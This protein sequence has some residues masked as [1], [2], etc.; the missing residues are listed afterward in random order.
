MAVELKFGVMFEK[1]ESFRTKSASED[2]AKTYAEDQLR[3][4]N[5]KF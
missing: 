4:K 3:K 1:C 2:E 5:K